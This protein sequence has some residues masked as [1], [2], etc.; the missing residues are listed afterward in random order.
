[1]GEKSNKIT[2]R[3]SDGKLKVA[4]AIKNE[5]GISVA[6][7]FRDAY[8]FW[9]MV[10]NG[11]ADGSIDEEE[12]IEELKNYAAVLEGKKKESRLKFQDIMDE[13]EEGA[14]KEDEE[15]ITNPLTDLS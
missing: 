14:E 8:T 1:M 2:V 5:L 6:K 3:I 4:E 11:L 12:A 10:V 9:V 7:Q 15:G 13:V